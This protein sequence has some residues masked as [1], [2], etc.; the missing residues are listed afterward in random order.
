[1]KKLVLS[2]AILGFIT[3]SSLSIQNLLASPH[4]TVMVNYDKDP[5]KADTKKAAD[6]KNAADT[7]EVKAETKTTEASSASC[8]TSC[9]DKSAS[10]KSCCSGEHSG[11]CGGSNTTPEKK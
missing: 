2:L 10:S 9:T 5:K 1:M 6:T 7:K 3:F 11:C 8:G 4:Q